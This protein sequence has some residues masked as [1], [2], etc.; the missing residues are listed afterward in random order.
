MEKISKPQL[1]CITMMGQIGSI[2]LWALGI[3]AGQDAWI[4]ILFS[5][6]ISLGFIWVYTSLHRNYSS[7]NFAGLSVVFLSKVI[8]FPWRLESMSMCS[9]RMWTSHTIFY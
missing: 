9:R 1:F 4:V 5:M 7:D 8:G 3:K 2:N 6:L